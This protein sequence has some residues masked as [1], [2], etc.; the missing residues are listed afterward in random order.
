MMRRA[1]GSR[2]RHHWVWRFEHPPDL[3]WPVL[4]DT[5]RLNEAAGLPK[6]P[7]EE[8]PRPD[9]SVSYY[10]R[11]RF[12]GF[13]LAWQE[14]PVEW[15]AGRWFR[16]LRLFSK[17]PFRS[18]CAE[19]EL[20]PEGTG[21][22][23]DYAMEVEPANLLGAAIARFGFFRSV[24]GG[25]TR[26]LGDAERFLAGASRVPFAYEGPRLPAG[27]EER[28]SALASRLEQT[29]SGGRLAARLADHLRSA[30]EVDLMH[31]RPLR[32]ARTWGVEAREAV[33]LCLEAARA[34]M[35]ALRWDLLCPRCRGAKVAATS[36]D[37]L[38]R[39]A[40]CPS[41]NIDYGRDFARNVELTF[42]PAAALR[43]L[44]EG[45]FCLFGPGTTPHIKL[46]I[47]VEA[48]QERG[49]RADLPHGDYRLRTLHPAGEAALD[50][51]AGGFPE[52]VADGTTVRMGA[53][54][55]VGELR[56]RNLSERPLT[57][58]VEAREWMRDALTAHRVTTL[59]AFRDLF[60]DQVL[61]PGDE[62]GI[63]H[64]TLM[65]TDLE[66]STALYARAGDASA[67]RLVR[68]HY[69]FLT[70]IVREHDGALVKT[71]GDAVMAAFA[72]PA[73][74]VRAALAVQSGVAVFNEQARRTSADS[75]PI[76]IKLGL[77][78]GPCIAVTLND[79]LDYFGSTVNLAARLQAQSEGGDI[80]LSRE[81]AADPAVAAALA[82]FAPAQEIAKLKGFDRPI[83][84]LRL[85]L[86]APARV[87]ARQARVD[88]PT[89]SGDSAHPSERPL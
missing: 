24:G 70:R 20:I 73:D 77:H 69:A 58:I 84:F 7:I 29:P 41:C 47:T 67:Y 27:A 23:A 28:L 22:R 44:A 37:R 65:F 57:F 48:G 16:H 15:V 8:I 59:Q 63:D 78:A 31:M 35:L 54:A 1:T 5:A 32:L 43:P 13:H 66:G 53:A 10:G 64:V 34:G 72:D 2:L 88:R 89:I 76:R 19:L 12:L 71:I 87:A 17:G 18:L 42:R 46:Q 39:G 14:M 9:G 83:P 36:L 52:I 6:H 45:E 60:S 4:A 74:S 11:A 61:R 40:H 68:E 80:V 3:V 56:M 26:L 85:R 79:R 49:V 30:Q 50:W 62:V 25:L 38:P 51:T 82:P 55:P 21:C 33:E 75:E 86:D 81:L